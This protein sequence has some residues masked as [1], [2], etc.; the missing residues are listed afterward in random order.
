MASARA[1]FPT[2]IDPENL[3]DERYT[4][5]WY[6]YQEMLDSGEVEERRV[7]E[8]PKTQAIL[9]VGDDYNGR[10]TYARLCVPDQIS[11]YM[12]PANLRPKRKPFLQFRLRN[13]RFSEA[14]CKDNYM[15][16]LDM[17]ENS[18]VAFMRLQEAANEFGPIAL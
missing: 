8:L 3:P 6:G 13:K 11:P 4:S 1:K 5:Q 16:Q 2:T 9:L 18:R 17:N 12:P 14:V 15:G 10:W 7:S